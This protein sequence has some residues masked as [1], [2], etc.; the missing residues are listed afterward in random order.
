MNKFEDRHVHIPLGVLNFSQNLKTTAKFLLCFAVIENIKLTG[1]TFEEAAAF[2]HHTKSESLSDAMAKELYK[3]IAQFESQFGRDAKF[4]IHIDLINEI[5]D[6]GIKKNEF[7][8]YAAVRSIIGKKL[9]SK[10][11]NIGIRLRSSGFKNAKAK[12]NS[13]WNLKPLSRQ[14]VRTALKNLEQ[15]GFI[16]MVTRKENNICVTHFSVLRKTMDLQ[17]YLEN[18][19]N[20]GNSYDNE[21]I[22]NFNDAANL[23]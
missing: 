2:Y 11:T 6:G 21:F 23:F 5:I 1:R 18:K 10:A 9:E 19:T 12:S 8:V 13:T 16:G 4:R 3:Y 14:N 7:R 22:I 20:I 17:G 15:E